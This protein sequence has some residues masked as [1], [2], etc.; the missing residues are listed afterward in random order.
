[1]IIV[2]TLVFVLKSWMLVQTNRWLWGIIPVIILRMGI[3]T[4][5]FKVTK[6]MIG[7]IPDIITLRQVQDRGL[8]SGLV[9]GTNI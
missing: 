8:V 2:E 7:P 5:G 3:C 6:I 1:M 9:G 4:K